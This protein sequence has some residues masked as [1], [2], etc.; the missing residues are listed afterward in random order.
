MHGRANATGNSARLLCRYAVF[1]KKYGSIAQQ[2]KGISRYSGVP[3]L[4]W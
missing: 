2:D 1:A 4:L 3:V